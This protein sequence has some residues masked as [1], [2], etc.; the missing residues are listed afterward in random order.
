MFAPRYFS[1]YYFAPSYFVP[2]GEGLGEQPAPAWDRILRLPNGRTRR[3][4]K[5]R[6]GYP[7]VWLDPDDNEDFGLDFSRL[8]R[9]GVTVVN[10][11]ATTDG[12]LTVSGLTVGETVV[13][14]F[15]GSLTG[16]IGE[17]T[18]QFELSNGGKRSF[19]MRAYKR[20]N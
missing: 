11:T 2:T 13:S 10:A 14:F 18:I 9:G 3:F 4:F 12:D 8:F 6:L 19:T 17:V 15:L 16:D 1:A 5:D 20:E 7:S